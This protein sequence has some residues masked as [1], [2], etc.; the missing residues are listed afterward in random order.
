MGSISQGQD[1]S[2]QR[3]KKVLRSYVGW[4]LTGCSVAFFAWKIDW[5]KVY[6]ALD[7]A[8]A[9]LILFGLVLVLICYL[10]FTARWRHI[11]GYKHPYWS[12]FQLLMIGHMANSLLPLRAGDPIRTFL[13][14]KHRGLNMAT[15]VGSLLLER[16]GDIFALCVIALIVAW[17][18][19]LPSVITH[20]L[21]FMV[22][23]S[24]IIVGGVI[25]I[26]VN[27]GRFTQVLNRA[28]GKNSRY[29]PRLV[30]HI[31]HFADAFSG[32]GMDISSSCRRLFVIALISLIA[33]GAYSLG[34][35]A[36]VAAF[37]ILNPILPALLLVVVTN[38]GSAIPSSP[39]SIGVFHALAIVA[40]SPWNIPLET[41]MAI[42]VVT[43][44]ITV[45]M[46]AILGLIGQHQLKKS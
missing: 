10:V 28:L 22:V 1:E 5:G 35:I 37:G 19:Q 4:I 38:L 21:Q 32:L 13:T 12:L 42:G 2:S 34:V 39:G 6:V 24:V 33:W 27:R 45:F 16:L 3:H 25:W 23:V 11:L 20:S 26:T 46:Q 44:L 9:I 36:C 30:M 8:D 14:S 17:S 18:I 7:Q 15:V 43:H 29:T 31:E 41:A 40:L